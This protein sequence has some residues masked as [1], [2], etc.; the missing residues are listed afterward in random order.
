MGSADAV[1]RTILAGITGVERTE[2]EESK[3]LGGRYVLT[4][5][6]LL[7]MVAVYVRIRVG[8]PV[9]LI[10]ECGCGK[11]YLISYLCEWLGV[12]L[13]VLDVH[14]GTT[15]TDIINAFQRAERAL[16]PRITAT[17]METGTVA[18]SFIFLDEV[19]TCAHMALITEAICS[20]SLR[21]RPLPAEVR[22]IA[23]L[24]PYRKRVGRPRHG[25]LY[26]LGEDVTPDAMAD[27]VYRVHPI[28]PSLNEF[29]FDFGA[30]SEES[31][32]DYIVQMVADELPDADALQRD[33]VARIIHACQC[34]IRNTYDDPSTTSLRDARRSLR[35]ITWFRQFSFA[36]MTQKQAVA[37]GDGRAPGTGGSSGSRR[38]ERFQSDA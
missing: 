33:I 18:A 37:P 29:A 3:I 32:K 36:K 38:K 13:T 31:E 10:G 2:E 25:L 22:I 16:R 21:G 30:L 14:G 7:K 15:D 4:M 23:A 11:T 28:P 26:N 20:R 17:K 24:N 9:V 19:N 12:P 5:D 8:I 35:L 6:N 27:L 1:R 34:Y